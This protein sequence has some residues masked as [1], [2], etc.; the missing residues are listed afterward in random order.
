MSWMGLGT[1]ASYNS[2]NALVFTK[3]AFGMDTKVCVYAGANMDEMR[4]RYRNADMIDMID[5]EKRGC[6]DRQ[7]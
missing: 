6:G 7:K 4:V 3:P 5:V 2:S 1:W